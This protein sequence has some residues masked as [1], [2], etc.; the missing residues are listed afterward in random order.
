MPPAEM[1]ANPQISGNGI[2]PFPLIMPKHRTFENPRPR[3]RRAW[4]LP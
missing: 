3:A 1:S 4:P 2:A